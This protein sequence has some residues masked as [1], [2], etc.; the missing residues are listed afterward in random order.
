MKYR[1]EVQVRVVDEDGRT[2]KNVGGALFTMHARGHEL[3]CQPQ[4]LRTYDINQGDKAA[5][6]MNRVFWLVD[7]IG[8]VMVP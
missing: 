1:L 2:V 6:D 3:V 8:K 5:D 7:H 4:T